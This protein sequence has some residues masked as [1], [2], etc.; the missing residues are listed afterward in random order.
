MWFLMNAFDFGVGLTR[1]FYIIHAIEITK[2]F[3]LFC[4]KIVSKIKK[5]YFFFK[6]QSKHYNFSDW[7]QIT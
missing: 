3:Y 2:F 6:I 1:K 7:V 4:S 5:I